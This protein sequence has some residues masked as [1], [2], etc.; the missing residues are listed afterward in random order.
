MDVKI[1]PKLRIFST[2]SR[3]VGPHQCGLA[4][5]PWQVWDC[6]MNRTDPALGRA[7]LATLYVVGAVAGAVAQAPILV[8]YT[9]ADGTKLQATFSPP[10]TSMGSVKL[11]YSGSPSE[12]VLPQALSADGGRYTEGDIEFWIKGK[13]ATLTRAGRSTTCRTGD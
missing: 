7:I 12:M 2:L 11:V 6:L 9:C 4:E 10:G 13:S 8:H 3:I 1:R 5:G